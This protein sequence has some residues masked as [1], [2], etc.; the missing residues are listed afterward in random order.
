MTGTTV[1]ALFGVLFQPQNDSFSGGT[2]VYLA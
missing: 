1:A 2:F